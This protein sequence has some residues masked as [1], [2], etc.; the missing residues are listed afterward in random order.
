MTK[1]DLS[2]ATEVASLVSDEGQLQ[3]VAERLKLAREK[4]LLTQKPKK[5]QK[6]SSPQNNTARGRA[7]RVVERKWGEPI[8][9]LNTRIPLEM[10]SLLDD[11]V[12]QAKK[13]DRKNSKQKL[14]AEAIDDLL[15]KHKLH[16]K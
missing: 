8:A 5:P 6:E 1:K 2:F 4:K 3:Q 9:S 14:V 15:A 13:R 12:Y 10:N 7:P 11:L 16:R